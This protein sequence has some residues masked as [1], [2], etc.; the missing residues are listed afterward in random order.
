MAK[1]SQL[2]QS[3]V[4]SVVRNLWFNIRSIEVSKIL[5]GRV[6]DANGSFQSVMSAILFGMPA[7]LNATT[8]AI[9]IKAELNLDASVTTVWRTLQSS[10]H[11]F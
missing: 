3:L 4:K 9:K 2:V 8:A 10:D 6:L 1:D 5:L 7:M 11:A